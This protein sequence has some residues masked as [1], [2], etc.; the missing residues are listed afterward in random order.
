MK[1]EATPLFDPFDCA[2][3]Y[4]RG[5]ADLKARKISLSQHS[6]VV[7]RLGAFIYRAARRT[8]FGQEEL[9]R[10]QVL[11]YVESAN[12]LNTLLPVFQELRTAGY[13]AYILGASHR[14]LDF[15]GCDKV[16]LLGPTPIDSLKGIL[17]GL[18]ATPKVIFRLRSILGGLSVLDQILESYRLLPMFERALAR[19]KPSLVIVSNDHITPCRVLTLLARQKKIKTAYLQHAQVSPFFPPLT[20]D[21]SLLDGE[22]AFQVYAKIAK[23]KGA[24]LPD[25]F[26]SGEKKTPRTPR[27]RPTLTCVGIGLNPFDDPDTVREFVKKLLVNGVEKVVLRLHPA[28]R[29]DKETKF[30]KRLIDLNAVDVHIAT[31]LEMKDFLASISILIAGESSLHIDA[32]LNQVPSFYAQFAPS[33]NDG[34][35]SD[36]YGFV[37]MGLVPKLPK[38]LSILATTDITKLYPLNIK[39]LKEVSATV[40]TKWDGR[41]AYLAAQ[42]LAAAVDGNT[43]KLSHLYPAQRKLDGGGTCYYPS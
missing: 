12:Q 1:R 4:A 14:N 31:D 29:G 17:R 22:R 11:F 2:F 39:A 25:I 37:S 34:L 10:K 18:L 6:S 27:K 5:P 42:T 41:E 33:Q 3:V 13:S 8:V 16:V 40:E 19:V 36:Y 9:A 30:R 20:F 24:T 7:A 26:L 35:F 23:L 32:L 15:G 43:L 21:Y 38:D 28:L